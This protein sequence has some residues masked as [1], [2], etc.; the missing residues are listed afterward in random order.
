MKRPNLSRQPF[1]D[2]RPVWLASGL[3]WLLA[4]GFAAYSVADFVAVRKEQRQAS[5]K[6]AQ[7]S[8][9][10]QE[11]ESRLSQLN[12]QLAQVN[13]KK[14]RTEVDS[15]AQVAAQ[16]QL[17]WSHL[18]SDLE[19]VVPWDVRLVSIAPTVG[20]DGRITVNL[21]GLATTREA[22]LRFLQKLLEDEHF[23][24]PV[25]RQEE[26]PGAGSPLGYRFALTVTY[27]P[28]GRP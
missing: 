15:V 21:E 8:N 13:W 11:L 2:T 25:P 22:W 12:R 23:S 17:R 10:A 20:N 9:R 26:A 5:G 28:E 27:H 14:L 16:R 7:L 24:R 4:L 1:L 18:L 3:V 6:L 19:A